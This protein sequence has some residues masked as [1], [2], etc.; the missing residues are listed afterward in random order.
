M[1]YRHSVFGLICLL[2]ANLFAASA[3]AGQSESPPWLVPSGSLTLGESYDTN[4]FV[5]DRTRL[6]DRASMISTIIPSIALTHAETGDQAINASI[7]YTP[8]IAFYHDEPT[9]SFVSNALGANLSIRRDDWTFDT[10]QSL[11]YTDGSHVAPIYTDRGGAPAMGAPWVRDRRDQTIYRSLTHIQY[12]PGPWFI[13]PV[14]QQFIQDFHILHESTPGYQNYVDRSDAN[15]GVD[16]GVRV[17]PQTYLTAG[18]RYGEQTQDTLPGNEVQ[19]SNTYQRAL[20]G[21]EGAPFKWLQL[22]VSLG[23]EIHHYG[24][25]I[26][27]GADRDITSL[28]VDAGATLTLSPG[29]QVILS[30]KKW[31]WVSSLGKC[32]YNEM[33]YQAVFRHRFNERFTGRL[34]ARLYGGDWD[35][36]TIRKDRVYTI[37]P[38]LEVQLSQKVSME[39]AW[40]YDQAESGVPDTPGRE[41]HRQIFSTQL[42]YAF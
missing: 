2:A 4:V 11:I 29:D 1:L 32:T 23:P 31:E 36:P 22:N 42:R 15:G 14:F 3:A 30:A 38:A 25:T 21:I 18:Y 37:S 24:G 10:T 33:T 16:V 34:T 20:F 19:A 41:F 28:F 12:N 9:E 5:Q 6:G 40:Q 13:R 7:N 17:M 26:L 27:D 35:D 39:F 8:E